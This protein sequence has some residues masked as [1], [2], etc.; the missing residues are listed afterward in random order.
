M[1]PC[2]TANSLSISYDFTFCV[3]PFYCHIR[4]YVFVFNYTYKFQSHVWNTHY[5]IK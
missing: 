4:R 1:L 3:S 5:M 2:K